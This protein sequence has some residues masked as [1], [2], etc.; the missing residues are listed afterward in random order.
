MK[1]AIV[2][3]RQSTQYRE[4]PMASR[5]SNESSRTEQDEIQKLRLSKKLYT[6]V[7]YPPEGQINGFANVPV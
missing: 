6:S 5:G 1:E 7:L 2:C 4:L 3:F